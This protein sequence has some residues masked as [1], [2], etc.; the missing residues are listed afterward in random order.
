[1]LEKVNEQVDVEVDFLKEKVLPRKF[2]WQGRVYNLKKIT[3]IHYAWQGRVKIYYFSVSDGINFFRL[4]FNTDNLEWTL[5][6][7]YID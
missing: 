3:L 2:F 4:V 1:M 7:V 5:D 6:E